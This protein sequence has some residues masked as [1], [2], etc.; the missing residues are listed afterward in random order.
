M[1][2]AFSQVGICQILSSEARVEIYNS[3]NAIELGTL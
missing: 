2:L 3:R 1:T